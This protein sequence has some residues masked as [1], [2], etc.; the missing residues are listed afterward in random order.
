MAT[1]IPLVLYEGIPAQLQAAD[2][3][4][5]IA[6]PDVSTLIN[7]N[8]AQAVICTPVYS[9]AA[10][11]YDFARANALATAKVIGLVRE[12]TAAGAAGTVQTGGTFTATTAQWDAVTGETGGLVFN[13][14]YFLSVATAGR[15]T[16]TAPTTN[17][18]IATLI[19]QATSTTDALISIQPPIRL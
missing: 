4:A 16:V 5:T 14:Y 2:T 9:S 1:K 13:T 17:P 10:G 15:L 18:D 3:L 11:S 19:L 6:E 8:A 7:A 12:T